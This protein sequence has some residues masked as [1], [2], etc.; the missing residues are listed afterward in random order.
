MQMRACFPSS[1]E[2]I[3]RPRRRLNEYVDNTRSAG[4]SIKPV[5]KP[6]PVLLFVLLTSFF[7]VDK[8]SA[9][10]AE[11]IER[12]LSWN[13]RVGID[14]EGTKEVLTTLDGCEFEMRTEYSFPDSQ[15]IGLKLE[16]LTIDLTRVGRVEQSEFRGLYLVELYAHGFGTIF[17]PLEKMK[18]HT[19]SERQD[20]KKF[21]SLQNLT[22]KLFV[23][24]TDRETVGSDLR[25]YVE[26]YC[27][28]GI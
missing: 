3:I 2:G 5:F 7:A 22:L 26:A 6:L 10:Q 15:P 14:L 1:Q 13:E 23:P 18:A 21:E 19:Y 25:D 24:T 8:A 17:S 20:G 28:K 16:I 9:N 12:M 4:F 11:K 27:S